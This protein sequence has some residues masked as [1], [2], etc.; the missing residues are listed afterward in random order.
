MV[1]RGVWEGGRSRQIVRK[2]GDDDDEDNDNGIYEYQMWMECGMMMTMKGYYIVN[3]CITLTHTSSIHPGDGRFDHRSHRERN[4]TKRNGTLRQRLFF[5]HASRRRHAR[6]S[7]G[8]F[9][10]SSNPTP[11]CTQP[12]FL[13]PP[14]P[15]PFLSSKHAQGS[16]VKGFGQELVQVRVVS[17]SLGQVPRLYG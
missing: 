6:V 13:F 17:P 11:S 2:K 9:T 4:E 7:L 5:C 1:G 15:S 12:P 3:I 14:F 16:K 10:F 8:P